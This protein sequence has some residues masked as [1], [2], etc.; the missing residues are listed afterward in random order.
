MDCTISSK[1]LVKNLAQ[2]IFEICYL[3]QQGIGQRRADKAKKQ[4][5]GK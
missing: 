5:G 3:C 4:E 2:S 1:Y